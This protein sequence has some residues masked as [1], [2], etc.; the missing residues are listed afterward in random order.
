M[1]KILEISEKEFALL[2]QWRK[3]GS[4]GAAARALGIPQS[5]ASN[6]K[7]RLVWRYKK[8]REFCRQVEKI[9]AG[10]P[11]PLTST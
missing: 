7:S 10:L 8:A 4:I 9:E 2:E 3:T 11:G 1:A 6:R 5:T